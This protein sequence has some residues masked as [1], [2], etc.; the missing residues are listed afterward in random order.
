ML[1]HLLTFIYLAHISRSRSSQCGCL[2][3]ILAEMCPN[4]VQHLSLSW[5]SG[6]LIVYACLLNEYALAEKQGA[7]VCPKMINN[8]FQ[9][10]IIV[11]INLDNTISTVNILPIYLPPFS[12]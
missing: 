3:L 1:R 12:F 8:V 9:A 10:V 4:L 7:C 11:A 6:S 5:R 2:S